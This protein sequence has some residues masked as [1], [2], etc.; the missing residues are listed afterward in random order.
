MRP[1]EIPWRPPVRVLRQFAALWLL[2][3]GA[4]AYRAGVSEG[5]AVGVTLAALAVGLGVAGLIRPAVVRPAFLGLTLITLPIGWAV[6]N[7]L[8]VL[9]YFAV[10]TPLALCFRAV[11]RDALQRRFEPARESYWEPK[12]GS[13]DP[14]RYLHTF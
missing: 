8:L 3:V 9:V 2:V 10:F 7:V 1:F 13:P 12:A 5:T 4:L 6:S 14:R 11:G